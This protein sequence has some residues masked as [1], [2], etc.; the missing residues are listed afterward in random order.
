MH[1]P[2]ARPPLLVLRLLVHESFP[3]PAQSA[4]SFNHSVGRTCLRRELS[5]LVTDHVFGYPHIMVYLAIVHLKNEADEVGQDG[6]TA[7]LGLDRRDSFARLR[8]GNR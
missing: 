8:T 2:S 5:Q 7:G 6:S 3:G 1:D 4:S